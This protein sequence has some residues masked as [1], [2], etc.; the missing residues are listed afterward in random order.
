MW[1]TVFALFGVQWVMLRRDES[2]KAA[3]YDVCCGGWLALSLS[4]IW[5]QI[6]LVLI[7]FTFLFFLFWVCIWRFI[8]H[9]HGYNVQIL[10][11]FNFLLKYYLNSVRYIYV[12][13]L[14]HTHTNYQIITVEACIKTKY[15]HLSY[16]PFS[17]GSFKSDNHFL[18]NKIHFNVNLWLK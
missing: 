5:Y 18:L 6:G 7:S 2:S 14:S 15:I 17:W 16:P 3:V 12:A 4:L 9:F 1:D 11:K 13:Q 8:G 10:R